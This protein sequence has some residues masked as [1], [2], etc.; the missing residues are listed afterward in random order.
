MTAPRIIR[1]ADLFCGGGG[2]SRGM[3]KAAARRG[4]RLDLLAVNHWNVAVETHKANH[5]EA[6]HACVDLASAEA[7]P[8]K[9]IPGG[10]LDLL[11]AS[12][13][14][15]HHS[16]A[17]G[18]KPKS[19]QSRASAWH[20]VHWVER[21]RVDE[22][23]L[24]NVREFEHWGPL[25]TRATRINGRMYRRDDPDPRRKGETFQ[26]FVGALRSM[27]MRVEW[28][29]VNAADHGDATE[30][31]RLFLRGRRGGHI[32]WPEA[33]H[34]KHGAGCAKWRPMLEI[35]DWNLHGRSIFNRPKPLSKNTLRRIEAG[36]NRF[37]G[38]P[39][40]AVLRGTNPTQLE[41][42]AR[43][44]TEPLPTITAGGGHMYLADPFIVEY[45][46]SH[47][48][49]NDGDKR[50]RSIHEPLPTQ[51]TENRFGLCEPFLIP[52][53]HSGRN[54]LRP[55]SAPLPTITT[56]KGGALGLVQ[57]FVTKYY[58]TARGAK[59]VTEPLDTITAKDRFALV[60]PTRC[61]ILFRMLQPHE[62]AAA[63]GFDDYHFEGNKTE[64]VRQIGNAVSVRT[65][66]AL[67]GSIFDGMRGKAERGTRN[68]E[69][70]NAV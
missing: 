47:G 41:G 37:G 1:S 39:F 51:T 38:K 66:E 33:T 24:E 15:T 53:E 26:A 19:D 45:H 21:L 31:N 9:L 44:V 55:V 27:G 5:P 20:V 56:A 4:I 54:A 43:A 35:I 59:P 11:V 17:R 67:C 2:T 3:L 7:D 57:P 23:L 16:N 48:A 34:H 32:R 22:L 64:V 13:E 28:R 46:G 62:L 6:R 10:R 18:G 58:G 40:L 12:P 68:D 25:L 36:L 50:V 29:I 65:A 8:N 42:C 61:D 30:R 14:C 63:M 49:R 60:E 70:R 69:L 52:M